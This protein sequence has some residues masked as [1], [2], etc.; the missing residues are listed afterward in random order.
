MSTHEIR[1]E[2]L[3]WAERHFSDSYEARSELKLIRQELN[4]IA[5]D[6]L[7]DRNRKRLEELAEELEDLIFQE[8]FDLI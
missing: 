2:D 6:P 5:G 7:Q 4:E 8:M 1:A 3:T